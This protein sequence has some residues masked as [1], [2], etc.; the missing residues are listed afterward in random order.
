[1]D[2]ETPFQHAS[3]F[4]P[5]DLAG[6]LRLDRF[7]AHYEALFAE[8]LAD[9]VITPEE[10][11][12]LDR[13]ATSLGLDRDRLHRLE[14]ALRAA[15]EA[16]HGAPVQD[17]PPPGAAPPAADEAARP[18]LAT[19][20]V[21]AAALEARFAAM[22]RRIAALEARA[23]EL[24]RELEEARS[25]AAFE[26][27]LSSL[28][29]ERAAIAPA[30]DD[31]TEIRRRLRLD[32][33]DATELR[34]L[35]RAQERAGD[36]DG[37]YCAAQALVY[38]GAAGEEEAAAFRATRDGN[39]IRPTAAL[40]PESWMRL[41]VHPEEEIVTGQIFAVVAPA[42]LV[43]RVAA[44]RR[45][46]ALPSIDPARRQ[47][48]R[49]STVQAVRCFSWAAA[50]LGMALPTLFADPD[51]PGVAEVV[52]GVPPVLRL[53]RLALSGR[54]PAELAFAAGQILAWC[55]EERFVC[56]LFPEGGQPTP[57]PAP[58][59]PDLEDIFLAALTIGSPSLPIAEPVRRR[60]APIARAIEPLLD[61]PALDRLRGH[62]LR[63]VEEGGRT[64]L[65]RWAGAARS[66]AHRAG[67]VLADDLEAAERVLSL[68]GAPDVK[69]QMDELLLF[70]VS[71]RYG[72]LRRQLGVA[73]KG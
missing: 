48:P 68:G 32:P 60:V 56:L 22:E 12:R 14:I 40:T 47:D 25:R 45:A 39:L 5:G 29:V 65:Q 54:S 73:V 13:A 33:R 19:A 71:E 37:R 63:F 69:A 20:G 58:S 17:E 26:V 43:G 34:R 36:L 55:R 4:E 41:L 44:L 7:E 9:G 3:A 61:P 35:Y 50:I 52:P 18:T 49:T 70:V 1:M 8:A 67:L 51:Y 31:L 2:Q 62:F 59:I 10:R 23:A 46:R 16:R 21:D 27:D 72:M 15:W 28:D 42:V 64:N 57:F 24:T 6:H 11:A 66:T 38:L 53:G 30:G